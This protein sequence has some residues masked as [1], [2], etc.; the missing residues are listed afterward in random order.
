M[1]KKVF[2]VAGEASGDTLGAGLIK[3]LSNKYSGNIEFS[4]IAGPKM[5]QVGCKSIYPLERLSVMGILAILKRY[6]ELS[7]K[8]KQLIQ[9]L[10]NNPP[11]VFIGIDAPEFNLDFELALKNA[12]IK[13]VHYVSPSVWAWRPKRILKIKKAV[14]LM[15]ALFTFEVP[16][17]KKNNID[18]ECVGH[19]LADDIP[20]KIDVAKARSQL[21]LE[22][23]DKVLAVLPGSRSSEIKFIAE[24]FIE[25]AKLCVKEFPDLKIIIPAINDQRKHQLE[26]VLKHINLPTNLTITVGNAREVMA[27]SDAVLIASGTATLEAA[28]LKKPMVVGYKMS[29]FSYAIFSRMLKI[30]NVSLPNLLANKRLVKEYI[31][32]NCTPYNLAKESIELL[33]GSDRVKDMTDEFYSIHESL[34]KDANKVSAEAVFQLMENNRIK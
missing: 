16:I 4:G 11:D 27:A 21:N 15:L 23:D 8:R 14:D 6:R 31:Q 32:N 17:Y 22:T 12:G 26:S 33:N 19:P 29:S 28:L 30:S 7:Q 13:T 3:E 9:Q 1:N 25:A 5:Q 18:V 20:L 34:K 24:P 2:I 10:I